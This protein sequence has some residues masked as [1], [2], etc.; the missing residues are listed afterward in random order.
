MSDVLPKWGCLYMWQFS[1]KIPVHTVHDTW[2]PIDSSV[3]NYLLLI[4][5]PARKIMLTIMTF[6]LSLKDD[7]TISINSISSHLLHV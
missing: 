4:C 1:L 3:Y 5:Q 7:K 2:L 6:F